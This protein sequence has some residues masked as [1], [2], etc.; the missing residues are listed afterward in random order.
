MY[1][2]RRKEIALHDN[3]VTYVYDR[4]IRYNTDTE[5]G[6][7]GS[8][9][10]NDQWQLCAL[11]HAGWKNADGSATN[12]GIRISAICDYLA[13]VDDPAL[14]NDIQQILSG[15][16]V[17]EISSMASVAG[18]EPR[19]KDGKMQEVTININNPKAHLTI[20]VND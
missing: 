11:H 17:R 20:N 9:V 13:G 14:A 4:V 2:P 6:S 18:S 19:P 5:G 1:R 12:E 7:S 3:N 8:P 15:T 10:F 16:E